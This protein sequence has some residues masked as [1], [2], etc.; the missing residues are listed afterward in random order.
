MVGIS[1]VREKKVGGSK[2]YFPDKKM[3]ISSG[4]FFMMT[5]KNPGC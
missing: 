4:N 3:H 1:V 2:S 5:G